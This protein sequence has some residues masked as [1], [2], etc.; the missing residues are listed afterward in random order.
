MKKHTL[1]KQSSEPNS[2][3]TQVLKLYNRKFKIT[4]INMFM[5]LM[6]MIDNMQNQKGNFSREMGTIRND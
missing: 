5:A 1:K 3:M 2:D 6:E 4:M